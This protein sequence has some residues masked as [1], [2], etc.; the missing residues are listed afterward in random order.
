MMREELLKIVYWKPEDAISL[1][2]P[3]PQPK[4]A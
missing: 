2:S 1:A 4:T 3:D